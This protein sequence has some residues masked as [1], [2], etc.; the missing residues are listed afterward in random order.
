MSLAKSLTAVLSSLGKAEWGSRVAYEKDR[1]LDGADTLKIPASWNY[2]EIAN[3]Q[4][5]MADGME[6]CVL[7]DLISRPCRE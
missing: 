5:L 1:G 3:A 6:R 2:F 7:L 4:V